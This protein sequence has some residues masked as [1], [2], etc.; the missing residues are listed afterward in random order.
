VTNEDVTRRWQ[1]VYAC[2]LEAA[3][4]VEAAQ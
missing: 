2:E 1:D 4:R 3:E